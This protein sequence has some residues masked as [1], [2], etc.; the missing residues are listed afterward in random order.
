[1]IPICG[2]F[3]FITD[4]PSVKNFKLLNQV[5]ML[6]A[7]RGTDATGIVVCT[8]GMTDIIKEPIDSVK[9]SEKYM[10]GLKEKISKSNLVI[11][12]TRAWTQGTP[13]DNNNNHPINSKSYIMVHNG[14]CSSMNRIKE[15]PYQGEVD[16]EILLSYVETLGVVDGLKKLRGTA[17][18]A[19]TELSG[20]SVY[21]WRHSNP[22]YIGYDLGT[23]T[24]F[25]ASTED[26]LKGGLANILSIFSS[27]QIRQLP[28]DVLSIITYEP[29]DLQLLCALEPEKYSY[30]YDKKHNWLHADYIHQMYGEDDDHLITDTKDLV[31]DIVKKQLLHLSWD[32]EL[33]MYTKLAEPKLGSENK[34]RYYFRGQSQDFTNWAR[35]QMGG[36]VSLDKTLIKLYDK[37]RRC[38]YITPLKAAIEDGI[39]SLNEGGG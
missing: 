30:I 21:L 8:K 22:L 33:R 19:I 12:H 20:K 25:F 18:I 26:I 15:Y 35:L 29:L 11:G 31:K 10:E 4:K 14:V 34:N 36:H 23:K 16:S 24:I 2:I 5:M 6:S 28:E 3:G 13:K 32:K 37:D 39:V 17:S 9:F 7:Q 1:M 27:Y 38:H